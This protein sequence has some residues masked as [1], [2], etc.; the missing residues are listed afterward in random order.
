M[1]YLSSRGA[2]GVLA[3]RTLL[4]IAFFC[5]VV[6]GLLACIVS[7]L[8][9]GDQ[10]EFGYYIAQPFFFGVMMAFV[11]LVGYWPYRLL[12]RRGRLGLHRITYDAVD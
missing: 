1:S 2:H 6:F 8:L 4:K 7:A 11:T 10:Y 12:A 9:Y 5:G 3:L